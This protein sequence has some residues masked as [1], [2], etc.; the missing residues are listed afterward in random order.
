MKTNTYQNYCL[1]IADSSLVLGHRLSELCGHGPVLEE[2]IA[3]TNIALDLI[4]QASNVYKHLA[5][6][7]QGQTEDDWVFNRNE[8]QFKSYLLCEQPNGHFGDTIARQFLFDAFHFEFLRK[9]STST[10][11]FL[12]AY[13]LKSIKEVEYHLKHSSQWIIRLGDGTTE[14]HE[15][16]QQSIDDLWMYTGELFEVLEDEKQLIQQKI[17]V[18]L[19]PVH[20]AWK[21][22]INQVLDEATLSRPKD[23][24][25]QKG[26]ITGVHTENMGY[27]LAEMQ[28]V[29]RA[30]P[31][32]KEW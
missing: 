29:R 15:K 10:D 26:G 18:D 21:N 25:M 16:I 12:N 8:R 9:L 7:N 32:A 11:S 19:P 5:S 3:L 4:G 1:R 20:Q 31:E 24:W 30:Y 17:A 28:Y 13:A 2:D 22:R 14:S 23:S 27:I 6:E